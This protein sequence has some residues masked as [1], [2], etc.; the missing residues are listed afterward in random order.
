[1]ENLLLNLSNGLAEAVER[2]APSVVRVDD[3]SRL[4]ATGLIWNPN[5]VIVA[6]SHGVEQD[7]NLVVEL[8]DGHRFPASL[9]GR[10]NDTDIAVLKIEAT[11]LPAITRAD[12]DTVKVGHL[13]L[14]LGR[15]GTSGLQ[16]TIGIVSARINSQKEG[17]DEYLLHTD[18]ILYP[19]F[20]GGPLVN[21]N[22]EVIGMN[23]LLYGRGKG[24]AV[25]APVLSHV[26]GSL[27]QH[28]T[29]RRGYLG[30]RTQLVELPASLV[31]SLSLTSNV[32]LLL[33][34][35]EAD[36]PADASGLL[37]GDAVTGINGQAVS[38]VETLRHTLRRLQAGQTARIDLLRGG[39]PLMVEVTLG[40][41]K[42]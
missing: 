25:G 2:A 42:Q 20:S 33:V 29:V 32:A 10:D 17:Q 30:V 5:G 40:T 8:G 13:A 16:A 38:D 11:G 6:T 15:P 3:H 27:L 18:A 4:T 7:E 22:G 19:G 41:E 24:V 37:P 14:A 12:S 35:I 39:T 9:I 31:T 34:G 26:V 28:G 36:G 21:V 1:M 23:N